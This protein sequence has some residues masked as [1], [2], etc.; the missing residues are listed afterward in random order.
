MIKS[1]AITK[2]AKKP[3]NF[4][5]KTAVKYDNLTHRH[6]IK[7]VY[8]KK[9]DKEIFKNLNLKDG[10]FV[11]DIGSGTGFYGKESAKKGANVFFLD[12]SKNMLKQIPLK[13]KILCD[14]VQPCF[15]KNS[16]DKIISVG[17]VHELPDK[18]SIVKFIKEMYDI[19]KKG[20]IFVFNYGEKNF[21]QTISLLIW[22][23]KA[24]GDKNLSEL[25]YFKKRDKDNDSF[26]K[27]FFPEMLN[28]LGLNYKIID[29]IRIKKLAVIKK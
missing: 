11:L 19:L 17:L 23:I 6:P 4:F 15:K 28:N 9:L 24:I 29:I 25:P 26:K 8:Y 20:G 14:A 12:I 3:V 27:S 5:S 18:A 1:D 13:N 22:K 21:I 7:K 16:F 10:D 2:E